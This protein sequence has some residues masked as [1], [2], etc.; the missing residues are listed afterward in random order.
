[1]DDGSSRAVPRRGGA[2][3]VDCAVPGA[4]VWKPADP[5]GWR[6]T[7]LI[8]TYRSDIS[9]VMPTYRSQSSLTV[10]FLRVATE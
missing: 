3:G 8:R 1:V 7:T 6:E 9:N 4:D 2:V 5:S 10:S